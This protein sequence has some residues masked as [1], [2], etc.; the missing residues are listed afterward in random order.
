MGRAKRCELGTLM[1]AQKLDDQSF[2]PVTNARVV[3]LPVK[4][5]AA[6]PASALTQPPSDDPSEAALAQ[7][8]ERFQVQVR[9]DVEQER[10]LLYKS[11]LV[12]EV[13]V[14]LFVLR[15]MLLRWLA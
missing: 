4:H 15:E 9:L 1:V 6:L 7:A 14:F 12:V 2:E 8:Y 5:V 3:Q 10:E 13:L 11:L